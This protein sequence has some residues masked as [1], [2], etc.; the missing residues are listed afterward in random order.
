MN[1][2]I[3]SSI[4]EV[5]LLPKDGVSL[6]TGVTSLRLKLLQDEHFQYCLST[7]EAEKKAF[8]NLNRKS[9]MIFIK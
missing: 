7:A 3:I 8:L 2:F 6:A 5:P 1:F 4:V 9:I